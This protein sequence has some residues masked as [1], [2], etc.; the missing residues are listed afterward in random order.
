MESLFAVPGIFRIIAVVKL[1]SKK[2]DEWVFLVGKRERSMLLELLHLYPMLGSGHFK[3]RTNKKSSGL[4][5]EKLLEEAL[6][7]TRQQNRQ[8]LLE[9]LNEPD[10]FQETELGFKFAVKRAELEWLLQILNDIRV[11]AWAQ[12]GSPDPKMGLELE[13]KEEDD[14][15]LI[16]MDVAGMYE[17]ALLQALAVEE[18]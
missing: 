6:A 10:R 3:K 14:P 5:D 12:L 11:G 15:L 16:T 2:G 17:T 18:F 8:R 13:L 1:L 7:E 9:M 4:L